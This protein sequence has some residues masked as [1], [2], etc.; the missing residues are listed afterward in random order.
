MPGRIY[1]G[2]NA[3]ELNHVYPAHFNASKVPSFWT[4]CE[5]SA[6][7]ISMACR[8]PAMLFWCGYVQ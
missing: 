3:H 2:D 5:P 1:N 8:L 7:D 4:A 6:L